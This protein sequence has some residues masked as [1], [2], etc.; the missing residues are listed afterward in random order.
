MV[1]QVLPPLVIQSAA[2]T[3]IIITPVTGL[4]APVPAGV[5][6]YNGVVEPKNWVGTLSLID[7]DGLVLG[8][9]GS[10]NSLPSNIFTILTGPNGLSGAPLQ[11]G[12]ITANP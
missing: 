7:A 1:S 10:A 5:T 8:N 9:V 2:S 12:T 11:G 6:V 4:I 3:S